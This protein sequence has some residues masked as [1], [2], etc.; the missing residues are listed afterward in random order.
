MIPLIDPEVDAVLLDGA[1]V[2]LSLTC[3]GAKTFAEYANSI[4]IPYILRRLEKVL[5]GQRGTKEEEV[6]ADMLQEQARFLP[7]G[8][9]SY[10][11]MIIRRT[12]FIFQRSILLKL[13]HLGVKYW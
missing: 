5:K 9:I 11:V 7:T 6:V 13:P 3:K 10:A 8:Q 1:A 2:I 4:F 12:F